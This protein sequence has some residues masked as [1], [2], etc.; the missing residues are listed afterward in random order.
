MRII[1]LNATAS[2]NS[3][4]KDLS[5]TTKLE[6]FTVVVT[7]EQSSGRGQMN[8]VWLSESHKNLM[9]SV[10]VS[11]DNFD[12]QKQTYLNFGV[13]VAMFDML[14]SLNVPRLSVK[15]PND[16]L[17][18]KKKVCGV[19]IENILKGRMISASIIGIGL[20]V[21]QDSFPDYLPDAASLKMILAK[22]FNLKVL[23]NKFIEKLEYYI[24]LL[25]NEDYDL[26]EELYLNV[27]HKKN[28]PSMF[29]TTEDVLFMGKIIGVNTSN[30]KLQIELSDETVKE[31]ALKE[32][33]FA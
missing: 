21:N 29:R 9:F 23:L 3:F 28:I 7:D 1:K 16:I 31:F 13:A 5:V 11:F 10:F 6:D 24:N 14:N 2:T 19:L 8:T 12:I 33:S 4:L 17:S 22:E 27:L 32:V 26:L 25:K 15:W 30:G 18:E 20:N